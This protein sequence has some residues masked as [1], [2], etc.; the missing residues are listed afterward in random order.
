MLNLLTCIKAI[1]LVRV[2]RLT[3]SPHLCI[4]SRNIANLITSLLLCDSRPLHARSRGRFPHSHLQALVH[5]NH[6]TSRNLDSDHHSQ[7]WGIKTLGNANRSSLSFGGRTHR[8]V[9][10]FL[11]HPTPYLSIYWISTEMRAV[12]VCLS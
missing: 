7:F 12:M 10:R 9:F 1:K 8:D 3:Q 11:V 5:D 2:K 6:I 4:L